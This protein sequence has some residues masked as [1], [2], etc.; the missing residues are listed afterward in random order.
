MKYLCLVY[1][2]EKILEAYSPTEGAAL[3]D[4]AL[5]YDD[6]LKSRGQYLSSN[7]LEFVQH[8]TSIRLRQGKVL[9]T[10][11]PFTET[12]EQLG[13][14]ILIEA[15]DLNEA[16][17]LASRIPSARLGGIEI[18]PVRDLRAQ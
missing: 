13:G 5:A 1:Q 6:E 12:R 14:Y 2:D 7:A 11:G 4:E 15:K 18:R 8:A 9:V 3:V 16:I 17:Q 10:D